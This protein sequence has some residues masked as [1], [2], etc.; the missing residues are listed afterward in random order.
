MESG[1]EG[2]GGQGGKN[3][4]FGNGYGLSLGGDEWSAIR[5]W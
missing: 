1:L 2:G 5:W 3:R 4:E